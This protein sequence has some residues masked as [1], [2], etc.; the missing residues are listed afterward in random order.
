M[1]NLFYSVL[2]LLALASCSKEEEVVAPPAANK[3]TLTITADTGGSVSSPGGMYNEGSKITITATPDGQY[4][5]EK[6]SDGSTI[7]P[8][9]ITVTSNLTIS[10]TFVK[11]TYPLSV[12]VEGEGTVQEEVIIQGST[13]QTEH[14]AGTTVRLTATPNEGWIFAG[15]SGDIESDAL[16]IEVPIEKGTSVS[17]LFKRASFE[18]NITIEGEGTVKEEVIVQPGQYDYE[19]EVRLTAIPA[20]GYEFSGWSGDIESTENP[21]ALTVTEANAV[22][23][24][25]KFVFQISQLDMDHPMKLDIWKGLG[26]TSNSNVMIDISGELNFISHPADSRGEVEKFFPSL[27]F[28]KNDSKWVIQNYFEGINMSF[29][30]RDVHPFGE[31][32]FVWADHGTEVWLAGGEGRP[33]NNVWTATDISRNNTKWTKVNEYRSFYHGVSSGDLNN[34]GLDDVVAVHMSTNAPENDFKYHTKYHVF[35]QNTDGSFEQRFDVLEYPKAP[36]PSHF[37]WNDENIEKPLGVI[38]ASILIEDITGDGL[39]EIIGGS[40]VHKSEWNVPLNAQ[41]SL[42]IF[43]D[44]DSDGKYEILNI[45]NRIGFWAYDYIAASQIK[46]AD[47]DNDGDKDLIVNFEGSKGSIYLN[48]ADFNGV[49]VFNNLG[50]GKFEYS[51]IEIPFEDVRVSEFEL[52][53]VDNDGDLDIVFNANLEID[54]GTVNGGIASAFYYKNQN[55]LIRDLLEFD[56]NYYSAILDLDEM[57]Y[58]ND[59]GTFNKHN[60]GFKIKIFKAIRRLSG[61]Q[62]FSGTGLK[63]LNA[64]KINGKLKFYGYLTDIDPSKSIN[65][66]S[67]YIIR[68]FEYEPSFD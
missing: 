65:D 52:I 40:S 59:G 2:A 62:E 4:L 19:T 44:I 56:E 8:R 37:S 17:A 15:W 55:R 33:F 1:K 66:P 22:T 54:L 18:L 10:A 38:R 23:A 45:Q 36:L 29:G 50:N 68:L 26:I 61:A 31:N 9:E 14:K 67:K 39:P 64:T 49:Q 28:I 25:F 58:Y 3:Y 24:E 16:V 34:D 51:G 57:I 35:Y 20:E 43:S 12:T 6:W 21:V 63:T 27:H 7:N 11:K 46:A 41:N 47:Y 48:S 53:D 32:G 42:E 5:F 13:S 30:G 60:N